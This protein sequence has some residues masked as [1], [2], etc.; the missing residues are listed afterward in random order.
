MFYSYILTPFK[1]KGL[2]LKAINFNYH[3]IKNDDSNIPF[4]LES[5]FE[6]SEPI[7]I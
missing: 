1:S 4:V 5:G 2:K 6:H 7:D 3:K